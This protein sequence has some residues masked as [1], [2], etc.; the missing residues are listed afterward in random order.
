MNPCDG[1][2]RSPGASRTAANTV[3]SAH[4]WLWPVSAE[5]RLNEEEG[6]SP[7]V[8]A[9]IAGQ[10]ESVVQLEMLLLLHTDPL[11]AWS[12]DELAKEL[13]IEPAWAGA[14]LLLLAQ[15]G[16]LS[17]AD[18]NG[19]SYRYGPN[20]P[21]LAQAVDGL[22]KAYTDRRVTVISLIYSKPVDTLK[23]FADAFR[24]R[25]DNPDG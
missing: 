7:E 15:R 9:F 12:A 23:T 22:A 13:R 21:E 8:R 24:L 16:L 1:H 11:R 20:T 17:V 25:K 3:Q 2:L 4:Q 10:I 18:S 5:T 19:A 6:I 14:Q